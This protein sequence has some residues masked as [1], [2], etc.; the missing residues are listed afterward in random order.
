MNGGLR[1]V[2]S[3]FVTMVTVSCHVAA[4]GDLPD[5]MPFDPKVLATAKAALSMG[6]PVVRGAV[7]RLVKHADK[8]LSY[9]PVSVMDKRDFP[10]SGDKHDFMSIAP[11]WWPDP[12]KPDGLPY[13]RKDGQVNPEVRNYPDKEQMPKVC[14][15][16][17]WL[18]LAYHYTGKDAYA[19]HATR[20]LRTW[21]L[22]T[23]TRMNPH[24]RYGQAVKGVTEGRAEG[25]IETRH[26]LFALEGIGL[27]RESK[28]WTSVD[29][30]GMQRWMRDFLGWMQTDPIGL[31]ERN[32][33]N[34]HGIWY[35]A[36]RLGYAQF[37]GDTVLAAAVVREAQLRLQREMAADGSFP[38][39]L[40]RTTSL[41]YSVFVLHAFSVIAEL[42]RRTSSNFWEYAGPNGVSLRKGM[43][44]L[45]PFLSGREAWK[46]PQIKPF[47]PQAAFGLL[48][49]SA[50]S[51]G[52]RDCIS[53]LRTETNGT[54]GE[55]VAALY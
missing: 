30:G 2:L 36:Q 5:P 6:D 3:L 25:L 37:I 49:V 9:K 17:Y 39:E 42:S 45:L 22:D 53:I 51:M 1:R 4:Q 15:N 12:S 24:M 48:S 52:C 23:A 13:I 46:Y 32:A 7:G 41:G 8:L 50:R 35:E 33:R 10:P 54:F 27:L 47:Q 38:L 20:L 21:F 44:F 34:N 31:D 16:V 26:F 40:A 55:S 18:A 29:H 43:D 11:Y 19:A 14:E 28:H